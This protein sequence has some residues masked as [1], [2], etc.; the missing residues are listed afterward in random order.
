[1]KKALVL[2]TDWQEIEKYLKNECGYNVV[3]F[4]DTK[5]QALEW[6][7]T[8]KVNL[9]VGAY[10][11]GMI[12]LNDMLNQ[13]MQASGSSFVTNNPKVLLAWHPDFSEDRLEGFDIQ[14]DFDDDGDYEHLPHPNIASCGIPQYK[15]PVI[16]SSFSL[17][18]RAV[19]SGSL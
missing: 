2:N 3:W 11:M 8:H 4:S 15:K 16:N 9:I 6:C 7:R 19:E 5:E 12:E 10:H 13:H 14:P 1:M 17:S 18:V